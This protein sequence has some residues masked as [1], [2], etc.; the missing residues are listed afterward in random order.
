[1][2]KVFFLLLVE[3]I[4]DVVDVNDQAIGVKGHIYC[5]R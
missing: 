5:N 1:M 3:V 2:C 4:N